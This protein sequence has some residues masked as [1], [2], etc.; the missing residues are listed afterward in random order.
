MNSI[1][2]R[3]SPFKTRSSV[4]SM[5]VVTLPDPGIETSGFLVTDDDEVLL[6]DDGFRLIWTATES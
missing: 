5:P 2:A 4:W 1:F 3:R 6:T